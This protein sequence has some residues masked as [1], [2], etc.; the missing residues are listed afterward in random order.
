MIKIFETWWCDNTRAF[1]VI[2]Y[3]RHF[4]RCFLRVHNTGAVKDFWIFGICFNYMN[5]MYDE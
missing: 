3:P 4:F 5:W 1:T 2:W